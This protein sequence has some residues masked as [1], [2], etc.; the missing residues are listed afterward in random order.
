MS[1]SGFKSFVILAICTGLVSSL[2][3][4]VWAKSRNADNPSPSH[5]SSGISG[6]RTVTPDPSA[7][8]KDLL[9]LYR[10]SPEPTVDWL[11]KDQSEHLIKQLPE[12]ELASFYQQL[13]PEPEL[14]G[15]YLREAVFTEL[16]GRSPKTAVCLVAPDRAVY[17]IANWG[18]V[19]AEA[20]IGWLKSDSVPA[21]LKDFKQPML[22]HLLDEQASTNFAFVE[23]QLQELTEEERL[24]VLQVLAHTTA[25]NEAQRRSIL[26]FAAASKNPETLLDIQKR[27]LRRLA[28]RHHDEAIEFWKTIETPPAAKA[29]MEE[30]IVKSTGNSIKAVQ[31]WNARHPDES[32]VPEC[33]SIALWDAIRFGEEATEAPYLEWLNGLPAGAQRDSFYQT[34]ALVLARNRRFELSVLYLAAIDDNALRWSNLQDI[35]AM[36]QA[37]DPER[38]AAWRA[39]LPPA[40][41]EKVGE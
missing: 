8:R 1:Q 3:G 27:T 17:A 28:D 14:R 35:H 39:T 21:S 37:T 22:K 31:S 20:A 41:L 30:E 2:G 5:A 29:Q 4:Y 34:T 19:D 25:E 13:D 7:I 23:R 16:S 9:D 40:D 18:K 11:L 33:V 10:T 26:K 38:A 24:P 15:Y 32:V 12:P 6:D 36:W